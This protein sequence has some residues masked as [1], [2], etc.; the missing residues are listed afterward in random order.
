LRTG[1]GYVGTVEFFPEES[2]YHLDGHR[3]CGVRLTPQENARRSAAHVP[4]CGQPVTVVSSI[5]WNRSPTATESRRESRR[6]PLARC[7]A[8]C[9]CRKCCRSSRQRA[10]LQTVER[11]YDQAIAKLGTE[12][13]ILQ[14]VPIEDISRAGSPLLAEAI[15][16]LRAGRDPRGRL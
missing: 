16:R 8:S 10:V 2:K 13:D 9:R 6:R 3:K 1:D 12:L 5:A 14:R 4:V 7:R 11:N 15:A